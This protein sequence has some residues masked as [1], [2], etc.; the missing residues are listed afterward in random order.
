MNQKLNHHRHFYLYAKDWYQ[1]TDIIK[2]LIKLQANYCGTEEQYLHEN[3]VKS[4]LIDL[5]YKHIKN[6]HQFISFISDINNP[7]YFI[8]TKGNGII[9]ACLKILANTEVKDIEDSLGEPDYTI[10]PKK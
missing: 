8:N 2:D 10:L 1:R 3:N 9:K 7:F 6:E 5:V 4:H